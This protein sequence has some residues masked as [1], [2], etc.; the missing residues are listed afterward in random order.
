MRLEGLDL[1][2][3]TV[4]GLAR[5]ASAQQIRDAYRDKSKKYHPDHGGDEWVFRIVA[6]A[7]ELLSGHGSSGS[8]DI[9]HVPVKGEAPDTGR[10]RA[11]VHDRKIDPTRIVA[12]ETLWVRYEVGDV[13][14]LMSGPHSDRDVSGSLRLTWPD[15]ALDLV[16]PGAK[17]VAKTLKAVQSAFDEARKKTKPKDSKAQADESHFEGW[18]SYPSGPLASTAFKV[19]HAGLLARGL[20]V[21]QWTRDLLM[22]RDS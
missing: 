14:A 21:R 3:L 1:D 5:G 9:I 13:L 11:G 19:V 16:P 15:P 17:E 7:Y 22:T 18:L 20:G 12:I 10:V 2:P 8:G 6:R 4:L